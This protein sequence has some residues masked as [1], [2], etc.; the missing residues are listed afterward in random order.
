METPSFLEKVTKNRRG[1]LGR[2][3]TSSCQQSV[4]K[5]SRRRIGGEA[6]ILLQCPQYELKCLSLTDVLL[7]A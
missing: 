2:S 7:L 4:R 1:K 3:L 5:K 6:R